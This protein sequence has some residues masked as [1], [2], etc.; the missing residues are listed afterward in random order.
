MYNMQESSTVGYIDRSVPRIY[1]SLD[2]RRFNHQCS[3]IEVEGKL[4]DVP[5]SI[6]FDYGASY[7]YINTNLVEKCKLVT[8]KLSNPRTVQLE[9]GMKRRITTMIKGC[10]F[11]MNGYQTNANLAIIPLGSYDV[12]IGMD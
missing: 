7:S 2:N 5:I 6:L 3:M 8:H 11:E 12:L 10:F 1:A 4:K 9:S